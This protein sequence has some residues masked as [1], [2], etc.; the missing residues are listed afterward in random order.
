MTFDSTPSSRPGQ[1]GPA[2][3]TTLDDLVS[4]EPDETLWERVF[5][6]APLVLIGTIDQNG[7]VDLAPKHMATPMGWG[8]YFGFV[9]TPRHGTYRNAERDGRFT[10][11]YL[12]PDQ[13][14][15]SSLTA[16]PR[17]E[18]D[19]KPIV[20]VLDTF[21]AADGHSVFVDGGHLYLE[22]RTERVIDGFGENS[23]IVGEVLAAYAN[24]TTLR[25]SDGD[26]RETIERSPLL[27]YLSPGRW[28]EIDTS[29][30]FPFPVGFER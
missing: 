15:L 26:D 6:V 9:C 13:I 18:D 27:A 12:R 16:A 10:V 4:L 5:T 14:V 25:V 1:D 21:P 22:C 29:Y 30:S 11:S 19:S 8:P 23:L 3:G 20:E 28:A 2:G 17:C 24:V 7:G